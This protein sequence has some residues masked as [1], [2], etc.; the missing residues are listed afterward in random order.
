MTNTTDTTRTSKTVKQLYFHIVGPNSEKKTLC[1]S[2]VKKL[3]DAERYVS[4]SM[5]KGLSREEVGT[6]CNECGARREEK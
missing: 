4:V 6:Q 2:C 3:R 5:G 1:R